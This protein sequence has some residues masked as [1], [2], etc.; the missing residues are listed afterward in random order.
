MLAF[1][2][3]LQEWFSVICSALWWCLAVCHKWP[4][5]EIKLMIRKT[6][7]KILLRH[8]VWKLSCKDFLVVWFFLLKGGWGCLGIAYSYKLLLRKLFALCEV[9]AT[10]CS[11]SLVLLYVSFCLSFA[12]WIGTFFLKKNIINSS[13]Q[14]VMANLYIKA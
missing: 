3:H 13:H 8:P 12:G 9:M 11:L 1:W 14:N 2:L 7:L 10:C 4:V 5:R 6:V